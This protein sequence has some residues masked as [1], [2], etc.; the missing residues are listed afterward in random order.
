[1]NAQHSKFEKLPLNFQDTYIGT[2]AA[3]ALFPIKLWNVHVHTIMNAMKTNNALEVS[4]VVR[5]ISDV[6]GF[7]HPSVVPLIYVFVRRFVILSNFRIR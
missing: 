3:H 7:V 1:M 2:D 4:R 6:H 5:V